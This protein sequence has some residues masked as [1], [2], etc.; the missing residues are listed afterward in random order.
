MR[1]EVVLAPQTLESGRIHEA[2]SLLVEAE[3]F[4]YSTEKHLLI[5]ALR[6]VEDCFLNRKAV[7]FF[8]SSGVE[9][10]LDVI[11]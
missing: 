7:V 4:T 11:D 10:V 5:A 6:D 2:F 8:Q 3:Q 1:A 9:Q